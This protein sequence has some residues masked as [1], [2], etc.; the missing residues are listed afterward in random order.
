MNYEQPRP[1]DTASDYHGYN[2]SSE[3]NTSPDRMPDASIDD[4]GP[5]FYEQQIENLE[6]K[7]AGENMNTEAEPYWPGENADRVSADL[8]WE[9]KWRTKAQEKDTAEAAQENTGETGSY[10]LPNR[11]ESKGRNTISPEESNV[12]DFLGDLTAINERKEQLASETD[13]EKV[14]KKLEILEKYSAE[15]TGYLDRM[16]KELKNELQAVD[17]QNDAPTANAE[18]VKDFPTEATTGTNKLNSDP[19]PNSERTETTDA[20]GFITTPEQ[21][22]SD[23]NWEG[24]LNRKAN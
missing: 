3:Y 14:K 15:M 1:L 22:R 24:G 23:K 6:N 2:E 10:P 11:E 19:T 18:E 4:V 20:Q 7:T 5:D 9:K 16:T 21:F 12:H 17:S 13:P 8:D